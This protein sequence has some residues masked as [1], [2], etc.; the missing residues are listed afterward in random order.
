MWS[1]F[2]YI[3]IHQGITRSVKAVCVSFCF[4]VVISSINSIYFPT[5]LCVLLDD[6]K[7][8]AAWTALWNLGTVKIY[9]H[10][11]TFC[12]SV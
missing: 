8:L 7:E 6:A 1:H 4:Q 10:S 3:G 11:F 12:M 9:K 5:K 2:Y